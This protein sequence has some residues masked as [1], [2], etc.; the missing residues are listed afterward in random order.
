MLLKSSFVLLMLLTSC[1]SEPE[2][3][4]VPESPLVYEKCDRMCKKKYGEQVSV[5]SIQKPMGQ[6]SDEFICYCK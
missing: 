2:V 5:Y 6:D 4:L 3:K 1:V